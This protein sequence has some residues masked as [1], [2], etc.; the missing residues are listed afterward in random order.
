MLVG[1]HIIG[2]PSC[3]IYEYQQFKNSFVCSG[4]H[5]DFSRNCIH[6]CGNTCIKPWAKHS[7][8]GKKKLEECG[9]PTK[10]MA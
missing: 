7:K 10:T 6:G 3:E 4:T 9:D 2:L 1:K 5:I 8:V